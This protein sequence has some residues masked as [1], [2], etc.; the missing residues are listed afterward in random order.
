M[1][2]VLAANLSSLCRTRGW[3]EAMLARR[4]APHLDQ[5]GESPL[6]R[7]VGILR[8]WRPATEDDVA[9]FSE[10]LGVTPELLRSGWETAS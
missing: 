5:S 10:V 9:A 8:A 1:D 3:S 2:K 7:V 4:V 6:M